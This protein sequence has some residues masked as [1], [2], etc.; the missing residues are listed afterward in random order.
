M[1]LFE[2]GNG[3]ISIKAPS[4]YYSDWENE[5]TVILYTGSDTDIWIRLSVISVAPKD[6]SADNIFDTVIKNGCDAGYTVKIEDDKSYYRYISE[7]KEEAAITFFYEIGYKYN[8]VIITL[9]TLLEKKDDAETIS[10][11]KDIE[12]IIPTISEISLKDSALFEPK[13]TD[14][15]GINERIS[16]ILNVNKEQVDDL[17]EDEKTLPLIQSILDRK[18]YDATQTAKL[19]SLG[20]AMGDYMQYKNPSF[21]WAVVRD[22]YGRDLCLQYQDYAINIFPMTMISK[23]IEKGETVNVKGLVEGLFAQVEKIANDGEHKKLDH[24]F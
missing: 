18:L 14:F 19:Q 23:R 20:I 2:I 24:N 12:E 1:K 13:Y 9:T 4:K 22:E 10:A 17:H 5:E 3:L 15:D 8:Y 16:N 7:S 11:L 6:K 21:H